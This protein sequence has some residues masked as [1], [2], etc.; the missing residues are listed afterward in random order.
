MN[1]SK[2]RLRLYPRLDCFPTNLLL[3]QN[4]II[5]KRSGANKELC[6]ENKVENAML[7][8]FDC[9]YYQEDRKIAFDFITKTENL[10]LQDG[11]QTKNLK[12]VLLRIL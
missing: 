11:G 10:N 7:G 2:I 1:N 12:E 9:P 8:L 6:N 5:K 3:C 4:D